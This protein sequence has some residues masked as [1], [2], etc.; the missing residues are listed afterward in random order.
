MTKRT[1]LSRRTFLKAGAMAAAGLAVA[2][3]APPVTPSPTATIEPTMAPTLTPPPTP[4][5]TVAPTLTPSLTSP[6]TTT[7]T[8]TLE[9]TTT[10][11]PTANHTPTLAPTSTPLIVRPSWRDLAAHYP[12]AAQSVVSVVQHDGV[13][14]GASIVSEVV[15]AMLDAAI[16]QLTGLNEAMSAWRALFDPGETVAI[17]VNTISRY[18][19]TPEVAYAV[20]Q[21]LQDAG[22]PAEQIVIFD[23]SV[24]ELS[25][26]GFTLNED[27]P[28]VRC[29]GVT[30]WEQEQDVAG[31]TQKLHDVLLA[32]D[33]LINIPPIKEHGTSGFTSAMKNHYGTIEQPGRL[34]GGDCDPFIPA[35]N[36][37]PAIR[38]KTRLIVCDALRTC[39]YNWDQMTRENL[40]MMSFDPVANDTLARQLLLDRRAAD[41][42]PG[43]YIEK[44]SHYLQT[45]VE[46]GLGADAAHTEERRTT[47]S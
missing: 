4:P 3:A 41:G 36:A 10:L 12:Q 7:P 14:D 30:A 33:A 42:K 40:I 19:T 47:L 26:Q 21:R 35:L 25:R 13:W 16:V 38:D 8:W 32:C 6:P 24:H 9:P 22:L 39:P 20:A 46:M 43:A 15:L 23:R 29:R 45:A 27:G 2:C 34:H 11:E 5:P 44:L 17:K 28:G 1:K 31:V 18:T 37:L